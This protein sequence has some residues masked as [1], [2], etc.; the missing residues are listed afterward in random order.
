MMT[1]ATTYNRLLSGLAIKKPVS[2]R[3]FLLFMR[4]L[5]GFQLLLH[6]FYFVNIIFGIA[7]P[8]E[9]DELFLVKQADPFAVE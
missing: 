6:L 7:L 2:Y 5:V 9:P 4:K 8:E 1:I 3:L